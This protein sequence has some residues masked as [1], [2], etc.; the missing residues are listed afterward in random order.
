VMEAFAKAGVA[1]HARPDD[2]PALS[3]NPVDFLGVNY[4]SPQR[5]YAS[6]AGGVLGYE[7]GRVTAEPLTEMGW[8]VH[9][10]GLFDL[11]VRLRDDYPGVA[12]VITENGAAYPDRRIEKGQV[13]DD[14]RIEYIASHLREARRAIQHG[15]KLDGYFLW[16]LMDNFEWSFGYS[17][18]FG[19]THVDFHTQART[20]KKSAGW[21]QG[22]IATN[23]ESL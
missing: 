13:Q 5:V 9:P 12:L 6:D 10:E 8:E 14:D 7:R 23:G 11:L 16:S 1:P 15:V 22:V 4:Y 21:Y 2:L 17:R 19:I 3:A 18:R 20:W